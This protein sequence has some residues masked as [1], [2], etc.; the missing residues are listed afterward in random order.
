MSSPVV[1]QRSA[2]E[3]SSAPIPLDAVT[4]PRLR[5]FVAYWMDCCGPRDMPSRSDVKPVQFPRLLPN[6]FIVRV[7]HDP[8]DFAY[9]LVGGANIEAHGK[10]FTN[11]RIAALDEVSPGYG[12]TMQTF[13]G[14]IVEKRVPRAARGLM[15]FLDRGF[16]EFEAVYLPF[17]PLGGAVSHI[18]GAAVYTVAKG[19]G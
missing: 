18:M 8:L 12:A 14:V 16:Y 15:D 6:M 2:V 7:T 11:W 4:E 13:Y 3:A 19:R 5:E 1:K 10:D 9:S 17:S